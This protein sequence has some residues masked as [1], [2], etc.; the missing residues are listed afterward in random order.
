MSTRPV[1]AERSEFSAIELRNPRS[2]P[3]SAR[4]KQ[5]IMF[6]TKVLSVEEDA[7]VY[8]GDWTITLRESLQ[9]QHRSLKR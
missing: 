2:K 5:L 7:M 4:K 6:D 3:V 8:R 1:S 9:L